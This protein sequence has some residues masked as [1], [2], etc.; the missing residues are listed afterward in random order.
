MKAKLTF[1]AVVAAILFVGGMALA[2]RNG[3]PAVTVAL[4]E[5]QL[6]G[7]FQPKQIS[8]PANLQGKFSNIVQTAP[9]WTEV[10]RLATG[11]TW[12]NRQV[13]EARALLRYESRPGS[14]YSFQWG[15][16]FVTAQRPWQIEEAGAFQIRRVGT[17]AA[18]GFVG[19]CSS[20]A[21]LLG[22]S[23]LWGAF[24]RRVRELSNAFRGK[25]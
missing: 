2:E 19:F 13:A 9:A 1:S 5:T 24:I 6:E 10:E 25:E 7:A 12:S 18:A 23:W 21:V 22:C 20:L 17:A 14:V 3:D 11:L 15:E 8:T 4:F 16:R